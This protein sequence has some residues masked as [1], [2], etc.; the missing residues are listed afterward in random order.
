MDRVIL[1]VMRIVMANDH[2][3]VSLKMELKSW[4]EAQGHLVTNLGV[5]TEERVDYPDMARAAYAEYE[6]G[7][8]D[9]GI[10]L[11]GTGIGISIAANKLR[12]IRC[13]LVHDEFTATMAREHNDA[14]FIAMGGRVAYPV[15]PAKI[16]AAF[17]NAS[18]AGGRHAERVAKLVELDQGRK[19]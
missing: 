15:P 11:C 2:G 16:L 9:F 17:M 5:D 6:K 19:A 4:L 13:A 18:F 10:L 3:A 14:N 12:G 8:Y 1:V 7:G